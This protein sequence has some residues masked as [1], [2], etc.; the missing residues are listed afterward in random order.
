MEYNDESKQKNFT[1]RVIV[2]DYRPAGIP[3]NWGDTDAL[4]QEYIKTMRKASQEALDYKVVRKQ[5]VRDY[6]VLTDGRQYNDTTWNQARQ[7]D[8]L[9]Y[10]DAAGNYVLADYARIINDFNILPSIRASSLH[11]VW[12]FGGPYF[13]FY[14]SRMV[15]RGAFWCNAPGLEMDSRRFIVMGFNYER[16]VREMVHNFGHRS[17]SILSMQFGSQNF[18]NMLY[19]Q[20]PT[21]SPNNEFESFFLKKGTVH[22]KPGGPEYG[23]DEI[24]WVSALKPEWWPLVIDPE[25]VKPK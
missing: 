3:P 2:I 1:R 10:R 25:K 19:A 6:P 24:A 21:P 18:Q 13:G 22:R 11:E 5:V 4:V 9:A 7:N 14:E 12:L 8:K 16:S 15:G 20:Q 23:Q 17:E